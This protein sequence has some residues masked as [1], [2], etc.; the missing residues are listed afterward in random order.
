MIRQI[1]NTLATRLMGIWVLVFIFLDTCT[2]NHT[3]SEPDATGISYYVNTEG[4]DGNDGSSNAPFKTIEQLNKIVLK[5]G[6]RIYLQGSQV[7]TGPLKFQPNESG[8]AGNPVVVTSYGNGQA[9]IDGGNGSAININ[10]SGYLNISVLQLKGSGRKEGNAENGFVISNGHHINVDSVEVK[11][12]QKAGLLVNISNLI[13]INRVYAHD[14]GF[15]GIFIAGTYGNRDCKNIKVTNCVAENNP[16]DP[17]NL[18]NHSGNGIIAGYCK[19]ILIDQC[20]AF[21]NGWD[22][23]RI[24]NGPVGIWCF[25][26]DSVIIQRCISYKNKTSVG[27]EDGGGYDLDGGVTNTIIQYCLSYENHGSGFGI[28]QYAGASKWHNNTVRFNISRNDGSVS[29]AHAGV[30][31]WNSSENPAEFTDLLFYNNI[32]YNETGA[33]IS[34]SWQSDNAGFK[35]YNNI[36]VSKDTLV[37]GTELSVDY[38]GNDWWSIR[39]GFNIKGVR[40]FNEWATANGKEQLNSKII[41]FNIEPA[42]KGPLN[43]A[44]TDPLQLPAYDNYKLTSVAPL[45]DKGPDLKIL[46]GID[47]GPFDFNQKPLKT[48]TGIGASF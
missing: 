10:G 4:S 44:I 11:G 22:M 32:I 16:G 24:G 9:V 30:Y 18:T 1:A 46:F 35:F 39:D 6:D 8:T 17:T 37:R 29:A 13:N 20:T 23:P 40:N 7:F 5:A 19:N 12:F 2:R 27:G 31:V 15:A 47:P 26:A 28:F 33:A 48:T 25:E 14:N 42:F 41:G 36:F 3:A 21:N 34:Y 45:I 38:K 43:G